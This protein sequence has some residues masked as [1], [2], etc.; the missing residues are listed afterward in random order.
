[1]AEFTKDAQFKFPMNR[2]QIFGNDPKFR[3]RAQCTRVRSCV[4]IDYRMDDDGYLKC[5]H[6][7]L[8]KVASK[9][10]DYCAV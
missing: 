4:R 2:T 7:Y 5:V 8:Q 9:D 10:Y 1:M 3:V 6:F